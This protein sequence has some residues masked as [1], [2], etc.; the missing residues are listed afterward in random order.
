LIVAPQFAKL[1]RKRKD[2]DAGDGV[3]V[4]DRNRAVDGLTKM[5]SLHRFDT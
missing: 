5:N 3:A 1:G 4:A 2:G